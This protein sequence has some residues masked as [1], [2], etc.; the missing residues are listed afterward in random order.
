MD[1]IISLDALTLAGIAFGVLVVGLIFGWIIAPGKHKSKLTPQADSDHLAALIAMNHGE[2]EEA[3]RLLQAAINMDPRNLD[4]YLSLVDLHKAKG[5]GEAALK[6]LGNLLD[7]FHNKDSN[8]K[9][10][11]LRLAKEEAE[12]GNFAASTERLLNLLEIPRFKK[13]LEVTVLLREIFVAA[14]DWDRAYEAAEL[15]LGNE[16]EAEKDR[17]PASYILALMASVRLSKGIKKEAEALVKKSQDFYKNCILAKIILAD[18]LLASGKS[19]QAQTAYLAFIHENPK[20]A[21]LVFDRLQRIFKNAGQEAD[22]M[23]IYEEVLVKDPV[24]YFT[25][26]NMADYYARGRDLELASEMLEQAEEI[27]PNTI[28]VARRQIEIY[29]ANKDLVAVV[30][31]YENLLKNLETYLYNCIVCGRL[32]EQMIWHCPNCTSWGTYRPREDRIAIKS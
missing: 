24:S 25:M 16:S 5:D 12:L 28:P 8:Y 15:V 1:Q 17:R 6:S 2:Y 18:L 3:E 9:R 21:H 27:I 14:A 23:P 22:I 10:V 7:T 13:D 26:I 11:I 19:S 20:L 4:L 31:T 30:D 32:D 29:M